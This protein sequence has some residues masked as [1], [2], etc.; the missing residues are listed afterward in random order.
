MGLD[1]G[2]IPCRLVGVWIGSIFMK[3]N[4]FYLLSRSDSVDKIES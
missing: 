3:I 4:D 2:V 1:L